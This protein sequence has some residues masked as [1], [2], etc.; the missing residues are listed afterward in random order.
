MS[1]INKKD[2]IADLKFWVKRQ[3]IGREYHILFLAY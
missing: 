2:T 1:L 3:V